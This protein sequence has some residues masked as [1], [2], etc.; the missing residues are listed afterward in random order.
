MG[1]FES[2]TL[3]FFLFDFIVDTMVLLVE[4]FVIKGSVHMEKISAKILSGCNMLYTGND[5]SD[6]I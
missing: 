4:G 2:C 6:G 1:L 3:W 5:C